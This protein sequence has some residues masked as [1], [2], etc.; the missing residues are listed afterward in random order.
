MGDRI[1]IMSNGSLR[2]CGSPLSLKHK[3]ASSFNLTL[4]KK[5]SDNSEAATDKLIQ[6]V[7]E[8]IPNAVLNSNINSELSFLLSAQDSSKFSILFDQLEDSKDRLGL[9]NAGVM[10]SSVEQVFLK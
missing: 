7:K 3:Y 9:V 10:A 5:Q 4:T 1:A 6:L 2:C 8:I